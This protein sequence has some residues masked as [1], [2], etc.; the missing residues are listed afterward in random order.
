LLLISIQC[1]E[2]VKQIAWKPYKVA[3]THLQ[4]H[5]ITI[6]FFIA[7]HIVQMRFFSE[8][9]ENI[10]LTAQNYMS[11]KTIEDLSLMSSQK[12]NSKKTLAEEMV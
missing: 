7:L 5:V 9:N 8:Y 12:I 2:L 10:G 6:L 11:G 3:D 4:L 1:I